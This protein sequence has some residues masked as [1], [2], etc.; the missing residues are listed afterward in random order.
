MYLGSVILSTIA[1][2]LSYSVA[3]SSFRIMVY[4]NSTPKSC[5]GYSP[6]SNL[7][8]LL[9]AHWNVSGL[10]FCVAGPPALSLATFLL[11]PG[12]PFQPFSPATQEGFPPRH[13]WRKSF[14]GYVY[15]RNNHFNC[16]KKEFQ[17]DSLARKSSE[18]HM[19]SRK[20][21]GKGGS[22]LVWPCH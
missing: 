11:P 7:W 1:R 15:N 20:I 6:C 5:T 16:R 19:K 13:K 17:I 4:V 9:E 22:Y 14:K 18:P 2:R 12:F 8:Q 3:G 10:H 21:L